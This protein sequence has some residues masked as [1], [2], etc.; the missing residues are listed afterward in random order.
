MPKIGYKQTEEH[1]KKHRLDIK[2]AKNWNWKGGRWICHGYVLKK[3]YNHPKRNYR[4]YYPEHRLVME[5]H[6]GRYLESSEAVHHINGDKQDN[7]IENLEIIS[8]KKHASLHLKIETMKCPY[9]KKTFK[10]KSKK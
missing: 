10:T 2:G 8:W 3:A 4:D 7:R 1:K 6:L 5:K 9:C